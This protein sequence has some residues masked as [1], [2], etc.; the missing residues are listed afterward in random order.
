MALNYNLNLWD[1]T[2]NIY[3]SYKTVIYQFLCSH[4]LDLKEE[5]F[6]YINIPTHK[7]ENLVTAFL[8][9]EYTNTQWMVSF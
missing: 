7:G 3:C 6:G 2:T 5:G 9:C 4:T 1:T 8:Y